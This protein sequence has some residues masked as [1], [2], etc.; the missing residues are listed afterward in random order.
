MSVAQ[1]LLNRGANVNFTPKVSVSQLQDQKWH[2]K[3]IMMWFKHC[4]SRKKNINGKEILAFT[5]SFTLFVVF[6]ITANTILLSYI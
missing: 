3:G 1:L 6:D 5:L 4:V 2:L